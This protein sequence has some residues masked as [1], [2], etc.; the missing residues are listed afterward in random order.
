MKK[1]RKTNLKKKRKT[2]TLNFAKVLFPSSF[3]KNIKNSVKSI[4]KFKFFGARKLHFPKYKKF[5]E[6]G[7]FVILRARKVHAYL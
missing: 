6:S 3:I 5:F 7:F 2:R 4:K 1:K